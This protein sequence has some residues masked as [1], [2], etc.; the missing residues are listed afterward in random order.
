[1][2]TVLAGGI[3]AAKFLVGLA[4]VVS[5]GRITIIVNIGDDARFYGLHVSPDTDTVMYW[6]AG[7]AD[8]ER[9][10]GLAG[11]TFHCLEALTRLGEE[12]WFQLGD[13][14]L[15]T[16]L[17]RTQRLQQ[18]ATLS[19]VTG[20]LC[21]AYGV[22]CRLLPMTDMPARTR[23][24]TTA[25][26]LAFQEYFV[27]LRQEPEVLEAD[28]S[29]AA[30]A[31]PAPGVVEAILQAEAVLIA[32]SNPILSIGPI[33][34]V[35]GIREA[36]RTTVAPVAA[37]SPIVAGRSLKG[38]TDRILRSL[39]LGA[40]AAS[41]ATLYRDFLNLFVL[42]SEDASLEEEVRKMEIEVVSAPTIMSTPQARQQLARRVLQAARVAL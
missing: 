30:C 1:M 34:A 10:W 5:P 32:P 42:D 13:R 18:G 17:W 8:F 25:G 38:P 9:G 35:P 31:R 29:E 2:I 7:V 41:V 22:E 39:G 16:H 21:R 12:T 40:S 20:Q 37:I 28:F 33:L 27:K 15:A 23:L 26:P 19:E 4:E 14:D 3:G 11:D 24:Q 36:L 6:L